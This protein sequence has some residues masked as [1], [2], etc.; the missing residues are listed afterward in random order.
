MLRWRGFAL[1]TRRAV[2]VLCDPVKPSGAKGAWR[3]FRYELEELVVDGREPILV[4]KKLVD[5]D[6]ADSR[7][8]FQR[9]TRRRPGPRLRLQSPEL[10]ASSHDHFALGQMIG[11][12]IRR[13]PGF[14]TLM[15]E[16]SGS[17]KRTRAW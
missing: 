10:P 7:R 6:H 8:P 1:T 5:H 3:M 11:G 16:P 14:C 13:E 12:L 17:A 2:L 15:L 9:H 4:R